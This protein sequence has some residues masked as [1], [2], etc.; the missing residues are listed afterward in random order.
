MGRLEVNLIGHLLLFLVF[1]ST[2]CF[3]LKPVDVTESL[4]TCDK[5]HGS[6]NISIHSS[7]AKRVSV[8]GTCTQSRVKIK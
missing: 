3:D 2:L 6:L 1:Y 7:S 8:L 4:K 5:H